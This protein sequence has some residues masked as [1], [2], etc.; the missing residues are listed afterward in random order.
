MLLLFAGPAAS[1]GKFAKAIATSPL[2]R[3][4]MESREGGWTAT[5][6]SLVEHDAAAE[7]V[8]L[9][10]S[11]GIPRFRMEGKDGAA[12]ARRVVYD[13]RTATLGEWMG[14]GGETGK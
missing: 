9:E 7:H 5:G 6:I 10:A 8:I 2:G 1:G 12:T 11:P 13:L 4:S 14:L 3:I